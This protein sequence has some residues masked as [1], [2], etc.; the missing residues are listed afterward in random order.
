MKIVLTLFVLFFIT[1]AQD[2]KKKE[3]EAIKKA[4]EKEKQFAKEQKFYQGSDYDLK[5]EEVDPSV[6]DNIPYQE[7]ENDFDMSTGVYD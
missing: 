3:Q 4:I 1:H 2:L 5:G 6:V 7:P